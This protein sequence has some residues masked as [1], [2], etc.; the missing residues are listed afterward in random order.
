MLELGDDCMNKKVIF[1]FIITLAALGALMYSTFGPG[2]GVPT[3]ARVN[4]VSLKAMPVSVTSTSTTTA[5][6]AYHNKDLAENFYTIQFPQAWSVGP[7]QPGGY[8]FTFQGGTARVETMDVPD[9][10]TLELFVLSQD[11]PQLRKTLVGYQRL[12]Y[13]ATTVNGNPAYRLT[14]TYTQNGT[15]KQTVRTFIAGADK[16]GVITLTSDAAQSTAFAS[17]FNAVIRSFNWEK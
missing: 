17:V 2:A 10:S 1:I 6:N 5:V 16:V 9:N 3:S 4:P 11:E 13:Q 8:T 15:T 12:D 14:Y 7:N